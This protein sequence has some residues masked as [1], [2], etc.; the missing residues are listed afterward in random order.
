LQLWAFDTSYDGAPGDRYGWS[1]AV[2]GSVIVAG[3][4]GYRNK[5]TA[6]W[7]VVGAPHTSISWF[8]YL[9]Y[10]DRG[11]AYVRGNWATL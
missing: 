10:A 2:D 6:P 1:V 4:Y 3:A 8:P 9:V 7:M 5:K 11:A